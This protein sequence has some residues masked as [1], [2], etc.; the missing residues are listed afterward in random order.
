MIKIF[1]K[2]WWIALISC[3]ITAG[4]AYACG[5]GWGDE[6][7][8]YGVSNFAP[9]VFVDSAYSPFF[10][11]YN[12]Y[13]KIGYDDNQNTRFNDDNVAEWSRY[14]DQKI[15]VPQL[16]YFLENASAGAI[17]SAVLFYN[18][19]AKSLPD[20]MRSFEVFTSKKN[21]KVT[22]FLRYLLLAKMCEKFSVNEIADRWDYDN[23]KK[24]AKNFDATSIN[25]DLKIGFDKSTD[26]FMKERYWFQLV[27]S[28]FFN[29]SPEDAINVFDQYENDMPRNTIY[30]RTLSYTAGAYYK[31]KNF[32]KANYYF[33][34]VYDECDVLKPGAHFSFQPQEE[35]DWKAT[36]VLCKNV[37]EQ[38]TLWQMLGVYYGDQKEAIAQI[39][40]LD[41]KSDKLDLLL[42][43][44]VNSYEQKFR[45][46]ASDYSYNPDDTS[47]K[48]TNVSVRNLITRIA[49]AGNTDQ[50]WVW[51]MAAG[52]LNTLDSLYANANSYYAQAERNI[53]SND[54]DKAQLKLL[55]I[56]NKIGS[57]KYID[58]KLET[59]IL[60]DMNW[61]N[62]LDTNPEPNLRYNDALAWLKQTVSSKYKT[63]HE[64][65]KAECFYTSN[66]FY[67]DKS[68]TEKMKA[69]LNKPSK[70]PF[71]KLCL[72]LSA[73]KLSDIYEFQAI[74]LAFND[75]T[76]SAIKLMR[77]S[78]SAANVILPAN[79]FNGGIQDCHD[80]DQAAPQKIKYSKLS[81]L[82]KLNELKTKIAAGKDIYTNSIL[83]ANA[84]YNISH[85][86]NDRAFYECTILGS[87]HYSP[88]AIDSIYRGMLTNMKLPAKYYLL[89][90]KAAKNNE[91]KAK[92]HYMLAKCERNEWYNKH[93][94]NNKDN[95]WTGNSMI[96]VS[97]L[98][99]F[100]LLKQYPNTQFYKEA[101]KE[102]GY[103]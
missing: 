34:R 71:E 47:S 41:P 44:A 90:L 58:S 9:E 69:F 11:S 39:Y 2:R 94:Y 46:N 6:Y 63:Q 35:S 28:G 100:K 23:V 65:V 42:S 52:Y 43:R 56:L 45:Y 57:A 73:I 16:H 81:F 92:C 89:A 93:F 40:K 88:F 101:L 30:Y 3:G 19:N 97:E 66:L 62:D 31:L 83:L 75:S 68:N 80:Y 60:S 20:S 59:D 48:N 24:N 91:Q 84:Y 5:G 79:P 51:Y 10:F 1:L 37:N 17:D 74:Q 27:R 76:E 21:E 55:E 54:L 12:Y 7:A 36:L 86:G 78:D 22:S 102:C 25:K 96:P 98:T 33:S 26:V 103:F 38:A 15:T 14:L 32:S 64:L 82:Q 87:G 53:P 18:M 85:Y 4:I 72:Q 67:A 8:E 50:P 61:L 13:Y 70:T 77:E 99:Q 29:D 95:Q 49:D